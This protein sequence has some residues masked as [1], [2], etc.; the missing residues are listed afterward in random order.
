MLLFG[1]IKLVIKIISLA[2]TAALVYLIVTAVQVGLASNAANGSAV[3]APAASEIIL[4]I[5][6]QT[7]TTPT[8][9]FVGR[10]QEALALYQGH[11]AT[12]IDLVIS[13]SS[14]L[15]Q[16]Q[17]GKNPG[18]PNNGTNAATQ[19]LTSNGVPKTAIANN[20]F[21]STYRSLQL[22]A[23]RL[24]STAHVAIVDDA[25]ETLWISHVAKSA[26]LTNVS[27]Y[28]AVGSKELVVREFGNLWR[29]TAGVAVGRILGF[30]HMTLVVR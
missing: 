14:T 28:P 24:G 11:I 10:L 23:Q 15:P 25:I 13:S 12:N 16:I 20:Y 19:W 30:N 22:I 1:P 4:L 21:G 7:S 18:E 27:I 29:Q 6:A 9:D 5:P 17:L 8:P 3:G 26:G 2:I